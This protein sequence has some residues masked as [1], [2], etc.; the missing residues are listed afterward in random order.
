MVDFI[1]VKAYFEV[2]KTIG[3]VGPPA[4]GPCTLPLLAQDVYLIFLEGR[5]TTFYPI[6][7]VLSCIFLFKGD[8]DLL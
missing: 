8:P 2:G 5:L 4:I 3:T 7:D 1:L 6:S